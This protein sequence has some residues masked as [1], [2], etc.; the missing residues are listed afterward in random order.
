M[1]QR[2]TTAGW[3]NQTADRSI[4]TARSF[5]PSP[6]CCLL[7]TF[8]YLVREARRLGHEVIDRCNLTGGCNPATGRAREGHELL[9]HKERS[10]REHAGLRLLGLHALCMCVRLHPRRSV[11]AMYMPAPHYNPTSGH[12]PFSLTPASFHLGNPGRCCQSFPAA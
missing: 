3:V 4:A 10:C 1:L 8:S 12:T 7:P 5:S 9:K 6:P 2:H 11:T